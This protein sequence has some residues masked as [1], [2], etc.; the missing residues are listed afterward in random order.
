MLH[1]PPHILI[2]DDDQ[3]VRDVLSIVF[4]KEGYRTE[5]AHDAGDALKKLKPS[6]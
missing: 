1:T 4:R 5:E 6:D 3:S 2:V